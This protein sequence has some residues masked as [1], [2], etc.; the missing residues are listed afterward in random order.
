MEQNGM[1]REGRNKRKGKR[2]RRV[3]KVLEAHRGLGSACEKFILYKYLRYSKWT[4]L[5]GH[6]TLRS[7]EIFSVMLVI[8]SREYRTRQKSNWGKKIRKKI[9]V[10][11]E[12]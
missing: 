7:H 12:Q 4:E 6:G 8:R 11:F 3:K 2:G 1:K 9:I 5:I 10:S